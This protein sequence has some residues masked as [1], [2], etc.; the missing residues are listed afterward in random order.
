MWPSADPVV[1]EVRQHLFSGDLSGN[2]CRD[3]R[4]LQDSAAT[5]QP[6]GLPGEVGVGEVKRLTAPRPPR[7]ILPQTLPSESQV[8][9]GHLRSPSDPP[10]RN[11]GAGPCPAPII[12]RV[13]MSLENHLCRTKPTYQVVSSASLLRSF[14]SS[15]DSEEEGAVFVIGNST[16]W[17]GSTAQP[18][19][20]PVGT[21][22]LTVP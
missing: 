11:L 5:V 8:L 4:Q 1:W 7:F 16:L 20:Q 12:P 9:S 14:P 22:A 6:E 13:L 10:S 15:S 17:C 2:V 18:P 19:A 21:T 3:R